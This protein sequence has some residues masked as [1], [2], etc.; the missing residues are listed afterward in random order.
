LEIL[1][2]V[3]GRPVVEV[4]SLRREQQQKRD[5]QLEV[6]ILTEAVNPETPSLA[7]RPQ[8]NATENAAGSRSCTETGKLQKQQTTVTANNSV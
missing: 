2:Q 5:A 3:V 1:L 6:C 7:A 8:C 4:R